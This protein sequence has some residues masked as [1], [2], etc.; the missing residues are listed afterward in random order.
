MNFIF[1]LNAFSWKSMQ[2][3]PGRCTIQLYMI[4]TIHPAAARALARRS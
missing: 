3:T 2:L 1:N 4:T